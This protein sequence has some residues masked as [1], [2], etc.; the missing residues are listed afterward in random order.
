MDVKLTASMDDNPR[1]LDNNSVIAWS[2]HL[3]N[4]HPT[5]GNQ[6]NMGAMHKWL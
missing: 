4:N 2:S 5:R 3:N 1:Y 6:I